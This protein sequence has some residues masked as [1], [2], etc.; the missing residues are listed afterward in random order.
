MKARTLIKKIL[1]IPGIR[2]KLIQKGYRWIVINFN[3]SIYVIDDKPWVSNHNTWRGP[4]LTNIV[5]LAE[6]TGY[7]LGITQCDDWKSSLTEINDKSE[8]KNYLVYNID[9]GKYYNKRGYTRFKWFAAKFAE[10]EL[11]SITKEIRNNNETPIVIN[12]S[13]I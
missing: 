9:L 2:A 3:G 8:I 11:P 5:T 6:A 1:D 10:S 7:C 13:K 4:D 12:L